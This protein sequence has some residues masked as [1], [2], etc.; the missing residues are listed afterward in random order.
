MSDIINVEELCWGAYSE[1]AAKQFGYG[2]YSNVD[3]GG[4]LKVTIIGSYEF[5]YKNYGWDDKVFVGRTTFSSFMDQV[6][7]RRDG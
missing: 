1:K 3:F 4:V 6:L 2:I 7:P 5:I